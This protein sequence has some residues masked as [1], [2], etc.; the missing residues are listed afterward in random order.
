MKKLSTSLFSSLLLAFSLIFSISCKDDTTNY[1]TN[2]L[3]GVWN[4]S[5]NIIFH[6]GDNDG[7]QANYAT[8]FTFGH[9]GTLT[10]MNPGP[11]YLT[12]TG[13]LSVSEDGGITGIITTTHLTKY[14]ETT[15]MNW[16]GCSFESKE[17]INVNMTWTWNNTNNNSNGYYVI[18]G[19]LTK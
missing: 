4:G 16:A 5:L 7:T 10:L 14:T 15:S 13:H 1:S 18:T 2:D 8:Q 19:S 11:D 6:G 12:N 17:K 3:N 9:D